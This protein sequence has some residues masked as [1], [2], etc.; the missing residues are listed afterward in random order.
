M[1]ATGQKGSN[2]DVIVWDVAACA[3]KYKWVAPSVSG[4]VVWRGCG[5]TCLSPTYMSQEPYWG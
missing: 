1:L 4:G 2:S 5:V 3:P